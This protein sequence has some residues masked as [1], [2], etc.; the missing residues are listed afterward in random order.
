MHADEALMRGVKEGGRERE[1]SRSNFSV[2]P[3]GV[4]TQKKAE[5]GRRG[6]SHG[7]P[8]GSVKSAVNAQPSAMG[9][10]LLPSEGQSAAGREG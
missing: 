6:R 10:S 5:G 2:Y 1:G 9:L 4:K 8:S 3:A 7:S